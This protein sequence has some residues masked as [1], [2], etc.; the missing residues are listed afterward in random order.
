MI[1]WLCLKDVNF[2]ILDFDSSSLGPFPVT[3]VP[4]EPR[5]QYFAIPAMNQPDLYFVQAPSDAS[6]NCNARD[7]YRLFCAM[8]H[9]LLH[10]IIYMKPANC[11]F[12][13]AFIASST[14]IRSSC[15]FFLTSALLLA[16]ASF[17]A[18]FALRASSS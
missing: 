8:F 10:S 12:S 2:H 1:C 15:S 3:I 13:F 4:W 5:P 16:W 18:T 17:S 9:Q 11:S 6:D 7:F 14:A